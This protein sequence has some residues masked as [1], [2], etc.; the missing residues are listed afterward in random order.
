[1]TKK[2]PEIL[3][4]SKTARWTALAIVAFTM[5][6]GYYL[7][8]VMAIDAD[9]MPSEGLPLILQR[10]QAHDVIRGPVYL[11]AVPVHDSGQIVQLEMGRGHGR[12]P[13]GTLVAFPVTKQDIDPG[14]PVV[15]AK[16]DRH[17]DRYGKAL[18]EG[19]GGCLDAGE[20]L[21]VRVPLEGRAEPAEV[22]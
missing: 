4:E 16:P 1:M 17:A 18:A 2:L 22:H 12:L 21:H 10:L 13:H 7:A 5:F 19:A 11:E 3:S 6:A 14:R 20:A 15:E 9:D 8:D